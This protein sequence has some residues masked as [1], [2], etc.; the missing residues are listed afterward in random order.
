MN[1]VFRGK[2]QFCF[3]GLLIALLLT[4]MMY[5]AIAVADEPTAI[6]TFQCIGI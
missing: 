1:Y 4:A 6:A 5:P 2:E 3:S